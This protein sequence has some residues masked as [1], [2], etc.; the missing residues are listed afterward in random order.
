MFHVTEAGHANL[1]GVVGCFRGEKTQSREVGPPEQ[2]QR[3]LRMPLAQPRPY[4]PPKKDSRPPPTQFFHPFLPPKPHEHQPG[5]DL[6][7]NSI[8]VSPSLLPEWG[9]GAAPAHPRYPKS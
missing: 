8:G 7:Q 1:W 2:S 5:H 6:A 3:D 4:A 9:F